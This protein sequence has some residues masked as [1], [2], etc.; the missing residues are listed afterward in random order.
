MS[1]WRGPCFVGLWI[2][3]LAASPVAAAGKATLKWYGHAFFL[4]TS[5][6]GVRVAMDPF[7][8]IG[9]PMPDVEADVVTL[10]HGHPDHNNPGAVKGR[11]TVLR[12]LKAGN[13]DWNTISF[14]RKDVRISTVRGYHDESKGSQRGLNAIFLIEAG[15]LRVAHLSDI[16]QVPSDETLRAMGRVDVLIV[17]VGGYYSIDGRQA[18]EIVSRLKPKIAIPSHYKTAAT[19]SWPISDE[20]AFLEGQPRVKRLGTSTV[21]LD[22]DALPDRTEVWVLTYR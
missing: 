6:Q 20:K 2:L 18:R 21:T 10:S 7:G 13:R 19:A 5:P 15:G 4:L 9:Y 1:R 12:G 3:L 8:K 11:P 17:P 22:P 14:R 16:G